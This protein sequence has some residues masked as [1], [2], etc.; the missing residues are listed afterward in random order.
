MT[1]NPVPLD[2]ATRERMRRQRTAET[3]PELKLRAALREL[4]ATGYR[5]HWRLPVPRRTADL[6]WPGRRLAVFV[7]GCF[8]HGCPEH[9]RPV[10]NNRGWW[11]AKVAGN[12]ARDA[13]TTA[14]LEAA[15][16]EVVRVWEH[17]DPREAAAL[18]LQ[19]LVGN[20]VQA[21]RPPT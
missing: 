17:Q 8:W 14:A 18:V 12:R 7:D 5:C 16:W 11:A 19:V 1:P 9:S 2:A 20:A 21:A 15:G 4:G 6:A 3:G 13:A 10:T